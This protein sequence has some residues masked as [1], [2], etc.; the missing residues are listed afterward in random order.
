MSDPSRLADLGLVT[1]DLQGAHL[2][3]LLPGVFDALGA[4]IPGVDGPA[5]RS[6]LGLPSARHV[7]VVL[8]DGLGHHQLDARKGHAPFLRG[9]ESAILSAAFPTTTATSLALLGT[10]KAAGLTG[11]TGY[12]ARNGGVFPRE[13]LYQIIDGRFVR[14]HG[15]RDMPIWGDA[16]AHSRE[17]LSDTAVKA[18]ID[19]IVGYIEGIQRRGA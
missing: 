8:L 6:T 19:A 18:R 13:R 11:M 10:G 14:S 15:D 5:A 16:F 3:L 17:G 1:P 12:T 7:V 2:G 4:D 9:A